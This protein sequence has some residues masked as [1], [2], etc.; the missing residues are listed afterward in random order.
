MLKAMWM[1]VVVLVMS[2]GIAGPPGPVGAEGPPGPAGPGG[3]VTA[4]LSSVF[5]LNAPLG[6]TLDVAIGGFATRWSSAPQVS[7]GPGVTV[8]SVLVASPTGLVANITVLPTAPVAPHYVTVTSGEQSLSYSGF[9]VIALYSSRI[10]G[11]PAQG[12]VVRVTV[13]SNDASMRFTSTESL[14]ASGCDGVVLLDMGKKLE[15]GSLTFWLGI[16]RDAPT[17]AC[18]LKVA[19][20]S[21]Q[22]FDLHGAFTVGARTPTEVDLTAP[23]LLALGQPFD[24]QLLQV[25]RGAADT[26][27]GAQAD[28]TDGV[29]L[30]AVLENEGRFTS[31]TAFSNLQV[32]SGGTGTVYLVALD[33]ARAAG[34][35]TVAMASPPGEPLNEVN[36]NNTPA[37]AT[38]TIAPGRTL[39]ALGPSDR[40]W[41]KF[42]VPAYAVGK[43]MYLAYRSTTVEVDVEVDVQQNGQTICDG[44]VDEDIA[45]EDVT[46]EPLLAGEVFIDIRPYSNDQGDYTFTVTFLNN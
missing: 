14:L 21:P 44:P 43:R 18:S 37:T 20:A 33:A 45:D 31:T 40:D 41:Y 36:L 10:E 46:T 4:S 12:G 9:Q 11:V 1:G 35:I 30:L 26:Y 6:A 34:T 23:Q 15:S 5:P 38:L 7:F 17:T 2:C 39:G 24:T 25:K 8:N 13:Q 19:G 3:E 27:Y 29:P 42:T 32:V 16:N 28:M 22:P